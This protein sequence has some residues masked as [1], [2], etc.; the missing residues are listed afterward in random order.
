MAFSG[1]F[2]FGKLDLWIRCNLSVYSWNRHCLYHSNAAACRDRRFPFW[3]ACVTDLIVFELCPCFW[4]RYRQGLNF[5]FQTIGD[6]DL[7]IFLPA[8]SAEIPRAFPLSSPP[9]VLKGGG[10]DA[11]GAAYSRRVQTIFQG[12]ILF[13]C[14]PSC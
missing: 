13:A 5:L 11:Q 6:D 10:F 8:G 2:F 9:T 14:L 1:P 7:S 12:E 4:I 3:S